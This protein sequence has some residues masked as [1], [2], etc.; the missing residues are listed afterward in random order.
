MN[1]YKSYINL[2][3]N[4]LMNFDNE[5]GDVII[6][7]LP[8]IFDDYYMNRFEKI[9]NI[10]NLFKKYDINIYELL[11][12]KYNLTKNNKLIFRF[13]KYSTLKYIIKLLKENIHVFLEQG[14]THKSLAQDILKFPNIQCY[15][16][17]INQKCKDKYTLDEPHYKFNWGDD[18]KKDDVSL[19]NRIICYHPPCLTYVSSDDKYCSYH[20]DKIYDF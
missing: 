2:I 11:K 15:A 4:I 17:F 9:Y 5:F 18:C 12:K 16:K 8:K 20:Q 1:S 3:R 6:R 19:N 14:E 13:R 7:I 10:D